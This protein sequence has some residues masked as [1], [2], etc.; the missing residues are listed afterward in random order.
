[1]YY[2]AAIGE[3]SAQAFIPLLICGGY[4]LIKEEKSESKPWLWICAGATGLIQTHILTT[5]MCCIMWILFMII[6][7]K[8]L[9]DKWVVVQLL[10]SALSSVLVNLWFL[11]PFLRYYTTARIIGSE[12]EQLQPMGLYPLQIFSIFMTE[13]GKIIRQGVR[14]EMPL[15]IGAAI[16]LGGI[17]FTAVMLSGKP[18]NREYKEI[19]IG[20]GILGGIS[21]LMSTVYFPWD[22]LVALSGTI[23]KFTHAIQFTFRWLAPA[24]ALL[25]IFAVAAI[26]LALELK[27]SIEWHVVIISLFAT[28]LLV[29]ASHFY[30]GFF[31][32]VSAQYVYAPFSGINRLYLPEGADTSLFSHEYFSDEEALEYTILEEASA[33]GHTVINCD[34]PLNKDV[35]LTL[36]LT[37]YENY[38]VYYDDG[39]IT[40]AGVG[41][42]MNVT[43]TV[44]PMYQGN[45][46]VAFVEPVLWRICELISIVS[47]CTI[48]ACRSTISSLFRKCLK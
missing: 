19:A 6:F 27:D 46:Q 15:S 33:S 20:T 2:R 12:M 37:R 11:L 29:P 7:I 5:Q 1:M 45:I 4:L 26:E 25:S 16:L 47:L 38:K 41:D 22:S 17:V 48:L 13:Q 31:D 3:F 21:L 44:P 18:Q 23:A 32:T 28:A 36:P 30:T 40:T 9:L 43:V 24:T 8:R 10:K 34:N 14:G 39:T 35:L 42:N